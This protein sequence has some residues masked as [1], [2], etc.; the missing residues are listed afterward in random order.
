MIKKFK[1]SCN[2]TVVEKE[3]TKVEY[4]SRLYGPC[5][6]YTAICDECGAEMDEYIELK[7][8]KDSGS[9]GPSCGGGCCGC[10]H[11]H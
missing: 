10:A 5:E 6:K 1:C 3:G 2:Q 4:I 8:G 11:S 7:A 9:S